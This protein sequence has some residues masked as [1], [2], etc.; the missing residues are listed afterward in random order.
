MSKIALRR[1]K[2]GS[3]AYVDRESMWNIRGREQNGNTRTRIYQTV[4]RNLE[5]GEP[6]SSEEVLDLMMHLRDL[7]EDGYRFRTIRYLITGKEA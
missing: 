5:E 2:D 6:L 1:F 4:Q 3:I 7:I